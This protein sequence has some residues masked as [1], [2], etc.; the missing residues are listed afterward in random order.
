MNVRFITATISYPGAVCDGYRRL[1]IAKSI[2]DDVWYILSAFHLILQFDFFHFIIQFHFR[3]YISHSQNSLYRT[4][5]YISRICMTQFS[6]LCETITIMVHRFDHYT[7]SYWQ[8]WSQ[9][10]CRV[11]CMAAIDREES[12]YVVSAMGV[13]VEEEYILR[14]WLFAFSIGPRRRNYAVFHLNEI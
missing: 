11:S 13:F 14:K 1:E 2:S 10:T 8:S 12:V 3:H 9:S 4:I 7:C 5:W 6:G